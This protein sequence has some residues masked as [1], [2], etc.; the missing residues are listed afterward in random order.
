MSIFITDNICESW[1][2]NP[3]GCSVVPVT[4]EDIFDKTSNWF[5]IEPVD[6]PMIQKFLAEGD[7]LEELAYDLAIVSKITSPSIC[8]ALNDH[9]TYLAKDDGYDI[10]TVSEFQPV[11]DPTFEI[12]ETDKVFFISPETNQVYLIKPNQLPY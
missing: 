11:D 4:I 6:H 1:F 10:P 5:D 9:L 8:E 3:L 7:S 2:I 12:V